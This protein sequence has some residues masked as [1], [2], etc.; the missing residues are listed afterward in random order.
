MHLYRLLPS[1]AL[2]AATMVCGTARAGNLLVNPGFDTPSGTNPTIWSGSGNGPTSA[3]AAWTMW[4]NTPAL[5]TTTQLPSTDPSGGGSMIDVAT[6]GA[7]NGIYQFVAANSVNLVSVDVYVLSGTFELGL[8][9]GGFYEATA[10]TSVLDTWEHLTASI[11]S[12][13][14]DEIFLYSTAGAGAEFYLD[15]AFAGAVPV[16]EPSSWLI[17]AMGLAAMGTA[18]A[19]R[20]RAGS[21][22]PRPAA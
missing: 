18:V 1:I 16:P 10:K 9:R 7:E 2:I 21:S 5:T 20:A 22:G 15:N 4:N 8:G 3:A 19:G 11:P 13:I 14:G 17:L 6:A 12:T